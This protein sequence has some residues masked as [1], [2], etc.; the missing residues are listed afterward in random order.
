MAPHLASILPPAPLTDEVFP[1][2]RETFHNI[3]RIQDQDL[4]F[5]DSPPIRAL[6]SVV[7][8]VGETG[9]AITSGVA[10][11]AQGVS[12]GFF[13]AVGGLT[14]S[15]GGAGIANLGSQLTGGTI[16]MAEGAAEALIDPSKV[17]REHIK[18]SNEVHDHLPAAMNAVDESIR[19]FSVEIG[20]QAHIIY[21]KAATDGVATI[22]AV[23]VKLAAVIKA[24]AGLLNVLTGNNIQEHL[25]VGQD[26]Y[27]GLQLQ[28]NYLGEIST[29]LPKVVA[30]VNEVKAAFET[31]DKNL[32]LANDKIEDGITDPHR[33]F[34]GTHEAVAD[35]WRA[36]EVKRKT[37][38]YLP[39]KY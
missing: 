13:G 10:G 25:R 11:V 38:T 1:F 14:S 22:A 31:L 36:F 6:V 16:G 18:Y 35:G 26:K 32:D 21:D 33:I 12:S 30:T 34:N 2:N 28:K 29:E 39:Y 8:A 5:L 37:M 27:Q 9:T 20:N 3:R 24:L 4:G 7:G 17:A 19:D 23:K 15:F